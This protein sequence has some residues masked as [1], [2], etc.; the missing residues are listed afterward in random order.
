M[1]F[2]WNRAIWRY[3]CQRNNSNS[4][5]VA[6]FCA[7]DFK[8]NL[9]RSS[10][11]EFR[12]GQK[13]LCTKNVPTWKFTHNLLHLQTAKKSLF[14]QIKGFPCTKNE[15]VPDQGSELSQGSAAQMLNWGNCCWTRAGKQS[16]LLWMTTC[17]SGPTLDEARREAEDISALVA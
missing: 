5:Y 4:K 9:I 10:S 2:W 14:L 3:A 6:K 7:L 13:C 12:F 16:N 1:S 11:G 17:A 15:V 8:L